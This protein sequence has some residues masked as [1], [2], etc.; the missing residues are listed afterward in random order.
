M[1]HKKGG[2]FALLFSG[3]GGLFQRKHAT[4]LETALRNGVL[5]GLISFRCKF[6]TRWMPLEKEVEMMAGWDAV[7]RKVRESKMEAGC[8]AFTEKDSSQLYKHNV[9]KRI[10]TNHEAK[11]SA[12]IDEA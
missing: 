8:I 7:Y 1:A 9:I 4:R 3:L 2:A 6:K 12:A 5:S 10:R 11:W